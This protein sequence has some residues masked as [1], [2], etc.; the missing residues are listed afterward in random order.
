[1][2]FLNWK[3]HDS[4]D[5]EESADIETLLSEIESS[6]YLADKRDASKE[7]VV[8]HELDMLLL[9]ALCVKIQSQEQNSVSLRF[10]HLLWTMHKILSCFKTYSMFFPF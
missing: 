5:S 10:S 9:R 8:R 1:M 4:S 2:S 3:K 7:L 6:T